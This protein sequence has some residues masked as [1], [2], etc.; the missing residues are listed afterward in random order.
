M[1]SFYC[2]FEADYRW[3]LFQRTSGM[4]IKLDNAVYSITLGPS[5]P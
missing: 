3:L 1:K 4:R 2:E 5:L